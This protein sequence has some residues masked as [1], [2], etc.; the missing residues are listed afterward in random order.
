[1]TSPALPL[2]DLSVSL[3]ELWLPIVVATI[4]VFF[5]SMIAWTI[6]PHHKPEARPLGD[7]RSLFGL[8]KGQTI[9][10]G[11][12]YFPYCDASEM[13]TDDGKRRYAE[14]PW[15]RL[16][17]YPKRPSMGA[18]LLGSFLLYLTVSLALAFLGSETIA[19]GATFAR[20]MTV[21]G[22]GAILAYTAAVM[23]Q[24]IWFDR[25]SKVFAAHLF[26]GVVYGVAT[27]ASFASLWPG[28]SAAGA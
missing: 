24:I 16:V 28:V 1:M 26:D 5:L 10:P 17:L 21:I 2:T 3:P 9:A 11:S 20:V 19:P 22:T 13:K 4:A 12:Y 14:G 6:A 7:E 27:G 15:G 8:I 18:S 25:R 23:P